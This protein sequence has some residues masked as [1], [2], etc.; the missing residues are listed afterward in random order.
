[1]LNFAHLRVVTIIVFCDK[2][3]FVLEDWYT[4]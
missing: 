1:M 4:L 3:L 2:I